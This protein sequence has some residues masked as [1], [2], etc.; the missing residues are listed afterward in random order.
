MNWRNKMT[1][2]SPMNIKILSRLG[3][4]GAISQAA[5]DIVQNDQQDWQM[6][7]LISLLQHILH[8]CH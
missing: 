8:S 3:A 1:D 7:D 2:F 5:L 4:S 6:K